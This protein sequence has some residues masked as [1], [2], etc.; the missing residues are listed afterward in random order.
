[1]NNIFFFSYQCG[2]CIKVKKI[3]ENEGLMNNFYQY[4]VDN[5]L[6][7]LPPQITRIPTLIVSNINKPLI[8]KEILNWI[9]QMKFIK[10]N[11]NTINNNKSNN[12]MIGKQINNELQGWSNIEM[13]NVSDKYAYQDGNIDKPFSQ[14]YYDLNNNNH[15]IIKTMPENE[16]ITSRE[17]DKRKKELLMNRE[18]Q[19]EK[20]KEY[21]KRKR[22]EILKNYDNNR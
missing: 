20:Y 12:E 1:M 15:N 6:D 16:K 21:N 9:N 10:Y 13:N 14:S 18:N 2:T 8:G 11:K 22:L 5:N 7:N 4:C 3:L 19:E 17:Q